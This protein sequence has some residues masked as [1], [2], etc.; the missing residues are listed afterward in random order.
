VKATFSKEAGQHL[1][2]FQNNPTEGCVIVI[3]GKAFAVVTKATSVELVLTEAPP[4]IITDVAS[5]ILG[6]PL[7]II[8]KDLEEPVQK[9]N[10][11]NVG[12]E[13]AFTES[14]LKTFIKTHPVET[15]R[16]RTEETQKSMQ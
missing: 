15:N 16:Q 3:S 14:F 2:A 1:D 4:L 5:L 13:I 6:D 8:N 11:V 10:N 12:F 9:P 7:S